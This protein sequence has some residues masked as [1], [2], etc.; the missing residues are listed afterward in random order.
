MRASFPAPRATARRRGHSKNLPGPRGAGS[1][2]L[3][4]DEQHAQA[5]EQSHRRCEALGVSRIEKPD[6]ALID[7]ADLQALRERHRR[8]L[9]QARPVM[10]MLHE[11]I[12]A[13]DSMVVLTDSAGIVLHSIGDDEFLQRAAH[14]ALAPGASWAERAKGTNAVGTVLMQEAPVL[15]HADE[16]YLHANAFLT[17]SAAPI[18]D[19]RGNLLGVL[20]VSGDHRSYHPHT[21]ALVKMSARMIENRWLAEDHRALMCLHFQRDAQSLGTLMDGIV[22]VD[23]DGRLVGANRSALEQLGQSAAMLRAQTLASVFGVTLAQ[24]VDRFRSPLATPLRVRPRAGLDVH[25]VARFHWPVW[26]GHADAVAAPL[27]ALGPPP[28]TRAAQPAQAG[29]PGLT[30]LRTGDAAVDALIDRLQ[31]VAAHDLPVHLVGEAGSGRATLAEA[32]HAARGSGR[33][34]AWHGSAAAPPATEPGD[35][36]FV[37]G[38]DRLTGQQQAALLQRLQLQPGLRVVCATQRPLTEALDEGRFDADLFYRL[39]GLVLSLPA[40]RERSDL[41]VLVQRIVEREAPGRGLQAGP[42]FIEALQRCPWPGNLHQLVG[43]LR[44]AVLLSEGTRLSVE[45]LAASGLEATGT[46]ATPPASDAL[47]PL[48][49]PQ[50]LQDVQI[51][52]MQQAVRAAGGNMTEAARR[53][54]VSRNTL[55]RKLRW[56]GAG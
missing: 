37:R 46:S 27:E 50:R 38:A 7:R 20:D 8:L 52:T 22:S 16:H 41:P 28:S 42:G 32:L 15:V 29:R 5:I 3:V 30:A 36:L 43:V 33:F 55:Y 13:T 19:P 40:L 51:A 25:L 23:A 54:G 26:A 11:Q 10:A 48:P 56:A 21:M 4:A 6:F 45:L 17:C 1:P 44:T 14:V 47:Q 35:T 24:L 2:A 49:S 31:R 39:T 9:D 18:H 12:V 34:V 53:L